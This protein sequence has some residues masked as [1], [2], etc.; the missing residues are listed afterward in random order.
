M[1]EMRVDQAAGLRRLFEPRRVRVLPMI[2]G[3]GCVA[4]LLQIARTLTAGG[5]QVLVLDESAGEVVSAAGVDP[6]GT[7]GDLVRGK[8]EFEAVAPHAGP[9]LRVMQVADGYEA[10][11]SIGLSQPHLYSTVATLPERIETILVYATR[12][13]RR[14]RATEPAGDVAILVT[15]NAAGIATAYQQLKRVA[16]HGRAIHLLIDGAPSEPDGLRTYQRIALTAERFL[17]VVPRL[18]G[19]L[20]PEST[21]RARRFDGALERLAA[22]IGDWALAEYRGLPESRTSDPALH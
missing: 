9:G 22:A 4:R 1:L 10:L 8:A 15:P 6:H 21:A 19:C 7:L 18:A 11:A 13:L 12:L 16:P 2:G 5:A 17:G 20:P 14:S 3:E